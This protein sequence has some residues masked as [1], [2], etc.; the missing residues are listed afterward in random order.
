MVLSSIFELG[1]FFDFDFSLF[2]IHVFQS[3]SI[4]LS[5]LFNL[6]FSF[7][8]YTADTPVFLILRS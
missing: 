7:Y 6:T 4:Y 8:F 1:F 2:F 3:S 5:S